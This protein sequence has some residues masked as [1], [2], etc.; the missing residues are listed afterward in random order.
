MRDDTTVLRI[1]PN[2]S[3]ALVPGRIDAVYGIISYGFDYS[4]SQE[5]TFLP[6]QLFG[7]NNG[8]ISADGRFV[9]VDLAEKSIDDTGSTSFKQIVT[10]KIDTEKRVLEAF[11]LPN[12]PMG[13]GILAV[14]PSGQYVVSGRSIVDTKSC[15]YSSEVDHRVCSA[16]SYAGALDKVTGYDKVIVNN[17]ENFVSVWFSDGETNITLEPLSPLDNWEPSGKFYRISLIPQLEYLAL[18]DSYSSGEGDLGRQANGLSYY[19]NDT[20]GDEGCHLSSRSYPFLLGKALGD[21]GMF[22]KSV[23]CSGARVR[24]DFYGDS[25]YDG[26]FKIQRRYSADDPADVRRTVLQEFT[27]GEIRQLEFV[28]EYR[29]KMITFT[30]GGNDVGFV[31]ILEYCAQSYRL[32]NVIPTPE[33]CA[34]VHDEGLRKSLNATIDTQ[35]VF[36][37]KFIEEVK[38]VSPETEIYVVGY[39]QFVKIGGTR[40][41][42]TSPI[43]NSLENIFI[44]DSVTRLNN[45]LKRVARD[46]DTYYVDI[47]DSL[48]GGQICQGSKYMTGPVRTIVNEGKVKRNQ[49]MYHPNAAGHQKMAERIAKQIKEKP[50]YVIAD[51]PTEES[52][53]R[54]V[55]T[56]VLPSYAGVGSTHTVQVGPG[57][58]KPDGTMS[59]DAYSSKVHLGDYVAD[60][61]GALTMSITIPPELGIGKHLFTFT[62]LDINDQPVQLQQF[63][64]VTG[65]DPNDIDGDGIPNEDDPCFAITEWYENGVDICASQQPTLFNGGAGNHKVVKKDALTD[66]VVTNTRLSV[67][68]GVPTASELTPSNANTFLDTDVAATKANPGKATNYWPMVLLMFIIT[69]GIGLVVYGKRKLK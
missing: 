8:T 56:A 63:V 21:S 35:Y 69:A 47:E 46:T 65:N 62:G 45:V 48:E 9:Y 11:V 1:T 32:F 60:A 54:V 28:K 40:C 44:R 43:L 38:R 57:T 16:R 27:P 58:I 51:I 41:L 68:D 50:G 15:H 17:D 24:P 42:P 49:N 22:T 19:I 55:R 36:N 5:Y 10:H 67:G 12:A 26:Q 20:D 23:A 3:D 59:G 37:K 33:T 30:G 18:G 66:S 53:A 34:Y 7:I 39:P 25:K 14:S 6:S 29:P 13:N 61:T 2:A 31:D 52:A 64:Y 4:K